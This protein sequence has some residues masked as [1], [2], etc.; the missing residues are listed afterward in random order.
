MVLLAFHLALW[1][2]VA[3]SAMVV[4]LI[5]QNQNDPENAQVFIGF[6]YGRAI[7]MNLLNFMLVFFYKLMFTLKRTQIQMNERNRTTKQTIVA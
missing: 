1:V 4:S 5:F 2:Q 3:G 6:Y 7:D